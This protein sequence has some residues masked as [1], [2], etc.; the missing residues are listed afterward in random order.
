MTK[1]AFMALT[2]MTSKQA[3]AFVEVRTGAKW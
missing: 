3:V 1:Q 2:S